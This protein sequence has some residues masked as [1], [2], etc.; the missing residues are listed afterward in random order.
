MPLAGKP[1]L[2]RM[3]ERVK[4]SGY[5]LTI[6][7]AIPDSPKDDN[8]YEL[9]RENGINCFRGDECDLLDRHYKAAL[10]YNAAVVMKIPSDCPLIDPLIIDKVI[11]HFLG[12]EEFDYVSN[13]HPATYPDG[14]DVEIMHMDILKSAWRSAKLPMEREHTTPYIWEQPYNYIIGNVEWETGRDYSMTHRFTIDYQEDY[15][16]IKRVYDELYDKNPRFGLEDILNLLE[17]KPEIMEINRK[18]AGVN[19]YR[20]HLDELKTI[21]KEQTKII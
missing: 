21:S 1:L 12:N 20:S 5:P 4:A 2:L 16:F 17:Q 11:S 7:I 18:Y 13:L 19:W 9:C 6:V 8:I 10:E 14:N 3:Y 15:D